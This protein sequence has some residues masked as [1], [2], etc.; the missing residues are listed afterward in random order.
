[1][2]KSSEDAWLALDAANMGTWDWDCARSRSGWSDNVER[3][4][5]LPAGHID[6]TFR[7]YEREIHPT[8]ANGCLRQSS[9]RCLKESRTKWNTGSWDPTAPC[10][11]WKAKA[12]SSAVQTDS[13]CG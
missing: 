4:H 6:G 7:S 5:G 2:A 9:G 8:I 12:M 13:P 11:G 1:M 10:G 3:I